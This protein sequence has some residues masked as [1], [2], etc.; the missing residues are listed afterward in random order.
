MKLIIAKQFQDFL[1]SIGIAFEDILKKAKIP[2]KLWREE[3]H[4][5]PIEYYN[6]LVELDKEVPESVIVILSDIGNIQM[7][8]P[9]L[10]AALAAANGEEA[11]KRFSKFKKLLGPV[12]A[13]Y[14]ISDSSVS[15]H[16]TYVHRQQELPKFAVLNEQLLLLS[17]LR[18]GTGERIVPLLVESPFTYE[19]DTIKHFGI[20][21]QK[22]G[23]NQIVFD[24]RDLERAFLTHNNVMFSYIEPEL[25]RQLAMAEQEKS[26][27]NFVQQEL[28][29]AIPGGCF[30][31]EHI[32]GKLGLSVRSL[33]RNLSAE[34][35]SYKEQLQSVQKS[36]AFGYLNLQLG[37]DEIA[38]LLGYTETNAF[39]RAFKHWTGMSLTEYKQK[40]KFLLLI[41]V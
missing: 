9:S 19:A 4:L 24:K 21:P 37:T 26:F 7:F 32:A 16:F 41:F 15:V 27:T 33:Q 5:N 22:A 8:M 29:S 28:L 2:N 40:K 6:M 39:L 18:T 13:E 1:Q 14:I 34:N 11:I 17:I 12:E 30:S 23:Y 20:Q 38:C 31:A 36:M 25:N 10:F 3:L 35:T